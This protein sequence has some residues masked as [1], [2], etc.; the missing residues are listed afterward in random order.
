[1]ITTFY[2]PW[3]FGGD[4]VFVRHLA[5]ALAEKGHEVHVLHCRDA[6]R[7]L[8]GEVDPDPDV[9]HP[10]VAVHGL[11]TRVGSLSPLATHQTG[12]ALFK[13]REI[14]RL[15]ERGFDVIHYHNISLIG[16]PAIL[17]YGTGIKLYTLHEYWLVCPTHLLFRFKRAPC[18]RRTC[19]LCTLAHARPPQWWR[20][21]SLLARAIRHVDA[22]LSPSHFGAAVHQRLG[23]QAPFV[24]LPNFVPAAAPRAAAAA[25]ENPYFLFVGRLEVAK[26]AHT[27]LPFFRR[28]DRAALLLAGAGREERHLRRLADGCDRIRFLGAVPADRLA[29]L[30]RGA[31]GVIVPSLT[32][33]LFPLVVL[34]AFRE[35][36][37]VV[38]RNLGSLPEIIAE[39]G[40]GVTYDD[41]AGLAQALERL[42]SERAWRDELGQRGAQAQRRLWSREAHVERYLGVIHEVTARRAAAAGG[43]AA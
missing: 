35:G 13:S 39:S 33:E 14:R 40:G 43:S 7:M 6:F 26:G 18:V 17:G 22:F 32:F 16:G 3:G 1:M 42:L 10:N 2:P 29:A 27:L 31:V 8:G 5:N 38:A 30:Y 21:T 15:L 41:E 12:R 9:D 36:T 28:W 20:H 34:E 23:V 25:P 11:E 24:H 19:T 37:P 4:A